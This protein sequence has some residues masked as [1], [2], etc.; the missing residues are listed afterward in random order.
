MRKLCIR[1][2]FAGLI[3]RFEDKHLGDLRCSTIFV[4]VVIRTRKL[5]SYAAAF[6]FIYF[7]LLLLLSNFIYLFSYY[8]FD[9]E[10]NIINLLPQTVYMFLCLK[11]KYFYKIQLSRYFTDA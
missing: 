8:F 5:Y 9:L 1:G 10:E 11:G 4:I 6:I 2:V 3:F 7:F